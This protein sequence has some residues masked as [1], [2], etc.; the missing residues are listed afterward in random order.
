MAVLS[1]QCKPSDG[2]CSQHHGRPEW[3]VRGI[4][5]E[6]CLNSNVKTEKKLTILSVGVPKQSTSLYSPM[7]VL[8]AL[9]KCAHPVDDE[10]NAKVHF[11]PQPREEGHAG[12]SQTWYINGLLTQTHQW[13]LSQGARKNNIQKNILKIS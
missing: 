7:M 9:D 2:S 10:Q 4:I 11:A 8:M 6:Q 5:D 1:T 13:S 3:C 12:T